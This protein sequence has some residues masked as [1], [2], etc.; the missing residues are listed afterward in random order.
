MDLKE[1]GEFGLIRRIAAGIEVPAGVTG[2]GD[3]CAV[4][5]QRDGRETLV[6]T[7]LLMD[8]VHFLMEDVDP[9]S[10]GWKSAAVNLSDIAAM[11]GQPVGTFLAFALPRGLG[12][13][14]MDAFIR[15]YKDI[16]AECGAPL[17][18]GDTTG[19]KD[20]LCICVTV[21]GE[22]AAGAA[23]RRSGARPGD[24]VCVT[25]PL[26]DSAGG[27]RVILDALPRG[28]DEAALVA[29]HYR[30]R[31][32]VAEGLALAAAGATAMMDISDGIG[33]D[34]R[35]ILEASGVGARIRVADLPLSPELRR[36]A[37]RHGWDA[38]ALA[39]DGGEDYELLF[40]L[41]PA[42]ESALSVPHTMIGEIVPG[43]GIQWLGTT[44]SHA[45]FRH[46]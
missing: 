9:Y 6:T 10:L 18:G 42:A 1:L 25:G 2:I 13:A 40:T 36:C 35:H 15:G 44:E 33:S 29:R 39:I 23:V 14:W 12:S 24:R 31:P 28:D 46:F 41:P 16:S 7:D 5:P 30:P 27:L 20:R 45:G 37:A 43:A 22:C 38:E 11:G 26:G 34:L 8:G 19:S 32:R 17:L 21:L 3:D 4:L